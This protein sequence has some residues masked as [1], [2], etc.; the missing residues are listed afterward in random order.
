MDEKNQYIYQLKV[1]PR[2]LKE[3]NWKD[4][5]NKIVIEHFERL[6]VLTEERIVI[7]AGRTL[8]IDED[9]FGLVIFE[10]TNDEEAQKIMENDPAV[11]KGIMTAQLHS[12]RV[13]L[14]RK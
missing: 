14:L 6:K 5:D 1:V 9:G 3:E 13:A 11:K 8:K 7:L 4:E 2:L 10:A 12:Y